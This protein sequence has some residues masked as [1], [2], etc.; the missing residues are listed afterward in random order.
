VKTKGRNFKRT[1]ISLIST[2][3]VAYFPICSIHDYFGMDN[4]PTTRSVCKIVP[5]LTF[6][7]NMQVCNKA[8][9]VCIHVAALSWNCSYYGN[10]VNITYSECMSVALVIQ[11]TEAHAPYYFIICD[12]LRLYHIFPHYLIYSKTLGGRKSLIM[13]RVFWF[14]LPPSSGKFII[15][16][17]IERGMIINLHWSSCNVPVILFR[18]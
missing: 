16:R 5:H 9:N 7:Q 17:R 1:G 3:G 6:L 11:H 8:V 13:K 14:S 18:F 10:S 4:F 2:P 15:W 12:P